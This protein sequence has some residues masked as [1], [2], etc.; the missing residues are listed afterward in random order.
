MAGREDALKQ[1]A[2]ALGFDVCRI[3]DVTAPWPA[4]E[5]LEAFIA[6]GRHGDMDWMA[7]QAERRRHPNALWPEA[8]SAVLVGLNYGPEADPLTALNWP[9]IGVI[10]VYAR[11]ADYHDLLKK[12]L[13][14]LARDFAAS[15]R[16][17]VKVFVDTAPL[18]EK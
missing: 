6:D 4:S 13:K 2:E 16:A 17:A 7:L 10:S 15:E 3:A 5:R 12:R 1:R 18:M 11:G 9:E 14:Q 8:R